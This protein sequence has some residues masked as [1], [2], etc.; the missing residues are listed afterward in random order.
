MKNVRPYFFSAVALLTAITSCK[1]DKQDDTPVETPVVQLQMDLYPQFGTET[2]KL[3]SVY[4][5][6]EG[7]KIKFTTLKCY[8]ENVRY[9]STVLK[10]ACLFDYGTNGTYLFKA[11]GTPSA[12]PG[13]STNIGV[14][15]S[16]NH[17]DPSAWPTSS[18]LNILNANDMH[19]G[20][21]PGYIFVKIEAKADTLVDATDNFDLNVVFHAGTDAFMRD[22]TFSAITW[23]KQSDVLYKGTMKVDLLEFLRGNTNPIDLKSEYTSHSAPGQEP[24]TG[25][26]V[27]NFKYA[28]SVE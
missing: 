7:Y 23:V 27:D 17:N 10:D 16:I 18:A 5:T 3:D 28:L 19:W 6:D 22:T 9:G 13:L 14:Q 4:V 21:N 25:K 26:V 12:F 1:K 11:D 2:M 20:W 15:S 24:L 8:L